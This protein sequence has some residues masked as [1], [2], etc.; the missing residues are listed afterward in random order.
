VPCD[1]EREDFLGQLSAAGFDPGEPSLFILEGVVFYLTEQALRS[2]L[3]RI[4]TDACERSVVMFDCIGQRIVNGPPREGDT[5]LRESFKE[6]GEPLLFGTD[7][8]LPMLYEEGF[9][10]VRISSFDELCLHFTGTY[11][12]SRL[13]RLQHVSLAS[14]APV[15]AP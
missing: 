3:R 7:D 13:F 8:T 4:A 2:T 10:H 1:L 5:A 6:T 15:V 14:R 9:R 11:D 12:P